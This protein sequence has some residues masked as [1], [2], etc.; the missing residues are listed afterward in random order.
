M[1]IM[2]SGEG[3]VWE[4]MEKMVGEG[5]KVGALFVRLFRPFSIEH[6]IDKMPKT[7]KKIAVL[8]RTKEPGSIGEPLYMDIQ[9]A[10]IE[11][12]KEMPEII[13]GRYG[14]SSKE[15]TPRMVK[16]VFDEMLKPKPKNHFTVGI[17]DDV[18][19][20]HLEA[21]EDFEVRRTTF[22]LPD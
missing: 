2:G 19:N 21:D 17:V 7:V 11:N 10:Y 14:L 13:G 8:D 16:G 18:T 6:F 3:A 15:F 20:T 4:A 5:E 22:D 12:G 9:S 1:I